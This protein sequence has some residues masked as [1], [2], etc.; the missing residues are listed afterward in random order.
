MLRRCFVW[1]FARSNLLFWLCCVMSAVVLG[2]SITN[3][4]ADGAERTVSN[5]T[6][7]TAP[8]KQMALDA[9][10]AD[11]L[12]HNPE[13]NFYSAEIAAAK[14]EARTAATW[15]NPEL[16]TTIGGKRADRR[17]SNG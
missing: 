7:A 1:L 2:A 13:L 15:A 17:R 4:D 11:V 6:K 8:T 3:Y 14:G 10:V 16:S 12:E 5:S 9:V